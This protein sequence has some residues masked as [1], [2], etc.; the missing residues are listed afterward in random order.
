MKPTLAGTSGMTLLEI[1]VVMV[2]LGMIASLVGVAVMDQLEE[3]K[4]KDAKIQIQSF[5]QALDLYKLDFG[6]YPS[7]SEG[8]NIL[9]SPPNNKKPYMNNIP[10]DPWG[11][12]FVY[13]YPGT[14]NSSSYDVESYGPDG[15]D[16]GG[17]DIESWSDGEGK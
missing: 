1:M 13:I 15:N 8:L 12:D 17:D 7:T 14:H 5:A 10:K 2:I 16:G 9:S 3:A 6:S 11:R 4:M